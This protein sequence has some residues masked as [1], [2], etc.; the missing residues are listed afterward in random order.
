MKF[1]ALLIASLLAVMPLAQADT[2]GDGLPDVGESCDDGNTIRGDG[3]S[4]A[5]EVEANFICTDA[6]LTTGGVPDGGFELGRPNPIWVEAST[7]AGSPLCDASCGTIFGTVGPNSGDWFAWFGGFASTE[8]GSVQQSLDI[9]TDKTDL[10]F[11][12]SQPRCDPDDTGVDFA[13]VLIDGNEVFR[14]DADD[15]SCST[16]PYRIEMVDLATASGGPYND[17]DLHQLRVEGEVYGTDNF[18]SNFLFDDFDLVGPDSAKASHCELLS[19]VNVSDISSNG[20][21]DIALL[22]PGSRNYLRVRDGLGNDLLK[23]VAIGDDPI[24]DLAEIADINASGD[25]EVAFLEEQASGQTRVRIVDSGTGEIV[26]NLWY[27]M[28]YD[29]I[30]MQIVPDYDASG[31]PEVAVMGADAT[32]AIRIQVRDALSNDFL[33]NIYLGSQGLGQDF[34]ALA[35]TSG[36]TAPEMG[37]LSV[38]KGN[39]QVR[40]Q[41]WDA[42]SASFLTNVWFGKV[43]QPYKQIAIP[44]IN[45]NGSDEIASIGVDA[46]TQNIRVQV[47]DSASAAI[48]RS[49][50]LGN[51]NKA[52]DIAV[53][54]DINDNGI[55]DLAILLETPAGTGR[56]RIQDPLSGAFVR[57]L[58]YD[59]ISDPTTLAVVSDYNASGYDELA[60]VGMKNGT[61]HVLINDTF[62]NDQVNQLNFFLIDFKIQATFDAA[63]VNPIDIDF[64]GLVNPGEFLFLGN[65]GVFSQDDVV[66]TNNSQMFVQN[67]DFYGTGAFLSPQGAD[68]QVVEFVLPDE[69]RAFAF[70]Y[71]FSVGANVQ[72]DGGFTVSIGGVPVGTLGYFGVTSPRPIHRV[73][74]TVNGPGVDL[75]NIRIASEIID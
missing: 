28:Q 38:L 7:N 59:G 62:T 68:P 24:V 63:V 37:I 66:I 44:D 48:L 32:D 27:G 61:P 4:A 49:I 11:A 56:V 51:V 13:R 35:D 20:A 18:A 9:G 70:S 30:S 58:F 10:T 73:R 42:A 54:N 21:P 67:N 16:I 15:P 23:S 75:D 14:I 65:P 64:E 52:K 40:M 36:N 39:D 8:I 46:L 60:V 50:W 47:R 34:L 29:P 43:Y 5:C 6:V 72:F 57:N 2:C 69:T 17:G 33:D 22:V 71:S 41:L 31:T 26:K 53:I 45:S 1:G 12:V 74:L 55:P 19:I 25:P 3:C